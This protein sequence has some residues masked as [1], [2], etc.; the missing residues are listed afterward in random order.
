MGRHAIP[1]KI[2]A[3]QGTLR[4]D[5]IPKNEPQADLPSIPQ[6]PDTLGESGKELFI[7]TCAKLVQLNMLTNAGI[8]QIERYSFAYQLWNNANS[9]LNAQDMA[10]D[11]NNARTWF[12]ILKESHKMMQEFEDRWGLSPA[13]QNKVQWAD[14]DTK[15]AKEEDEFDI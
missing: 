4:K 14:V 11:V 13:S 1:N 12:N 9:H 6:P 7:R 5:R 15:K 8:P 10:K 2:K 3:I